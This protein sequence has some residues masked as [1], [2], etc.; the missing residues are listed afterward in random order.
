MV[1]IVDISSNQKN[2]IELLIHRA[3]TLKFIFHHGQ[4]L[5]FYA[6][7]R[8]DERVTWKREDN[9]QLSFNFFFE[10]Y[11]WKCWIGIK[12]II[13]I[14]LIIP[15]LVLYCS[16]G[17]IHNYVTS[18]CNLESSFSIQRFHYRKKGKA[19]ARSAFM[20]YSLLSTNSFVF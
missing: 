3:V 13:R 16:T 18:I 15:F 1:W 5:Q 9:L 12:L 2:L 20:A 19:I 11:S 10:T 8:R 14:D 6:S 4:Y 7:G 17:P